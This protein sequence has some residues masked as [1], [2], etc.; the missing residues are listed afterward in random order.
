MLGTDNLVYVPTLALA[1]TT[2]IGALQQLSGNTTDFLDGTNAFQHLANA[3]Q[4]TIWS[5]R[6]RSF[7]AVGNSTFEVDQRNVGTSV[8]LG[9]GNVYPNVCDRWSVDKN[10]ATATITAQKFSNA[11]AGIPIPGTNFYISDSYLVLTV[12]TP[13]ATLAPGEYIAYHQ[14]IEGPRLRELYGD[15]HSLSLLAFCTVPLNFSVSIRDSKTAYSLVSSVSIPTANAW[16][17]VKLPNLPIFSSSSGNWNQL[18]GN[19]GYFLDVCLGCGSTY[20]V[21]AAGVWQAGNF[22]GIA[23]M[24]NFLA[25]AGAK[26]YLAFVQHE[27]GPLC[28]TLI[29]CPFT[30]NY[31]DCL[32]YFCKS[33]PYDTKPGS[34]SQNSFAC[35]KCPTAVASGPFGM[36]GGARFPKP[37][38][39]F[40]TCVAYSHASGAANSAEGWYASAGTVLNTQVTYG[41]SAVACTPSGIT[42]LTVP[43]GVSTAP[44]E[45]YAEWTADTGW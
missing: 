11:S 15:V 43:S 29:D 39:A 9:A 17:L 7:N 23:G 19:I 8:S 20:N 36:Y 32:R 21:P 10:A 2:K 44:P 42:Y 35:F 26:F 34:P 13:Q 1:T 14:V 25:T 22:F 28:T 31:D 37:M 3:V 41:I 38:A 6:L 5:A 33:Y 18:P 24:S 16:T 45:A 12:G 30:Q 27:P 40:P 4:P